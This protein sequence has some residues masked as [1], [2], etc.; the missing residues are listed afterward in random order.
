M[1]NFPWRK[2]KMKQIVFKDVG[3]GSSTISKQADQDFLGRGK[4]DQNI[5]LIM[6]NYSNSCISLY[7]VNQ[8]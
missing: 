7:G 5:L 8:I 2:P 3:K 6:H 1:H 4:K